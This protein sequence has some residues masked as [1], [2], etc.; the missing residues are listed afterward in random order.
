M[1]AWPTL[2]T[3]T[4][5]VPNTMAQ[6]RSAGPR[7]VGLS[8]AAEARTRSTAEVLPSRLL[9]RQDPLAGQ[10]GVP[11]G[12][13]W[14]RILYQ[15]RAKVEHGLPTRRERRIQAIDGRRSHVRCLLSPRAPGR[16]SHP[17]PWRGMPSSTSWTTLE[18]ETELLEGHPP[19]MRTGQGVTRLLARRRQRPF[20]R[21]VC[22]AVT[23][24]PS[25]R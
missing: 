7:P 21:L 13:D 4:R 20:L 24:V 16:R 18:I 19:F 14:K 5:P 25:R 23:S 17:D 9:L 12:T 22:H 8:G 3:R 15:R 6:K 1:S 10:P 11:S 2:S